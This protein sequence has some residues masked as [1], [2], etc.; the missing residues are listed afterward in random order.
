MDLRYI[1]TPITHKHHIITKMI[2]DAQKS[3]QAQIEQVIEGFI[4]PRPWWMPEFIWTRLVRRLFVVVQWPGN[5]AGENFS[6][7]GV[8]GHE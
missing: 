1:G 2:S 4:R 3:H 5:V 6:M 8:Q 7:T